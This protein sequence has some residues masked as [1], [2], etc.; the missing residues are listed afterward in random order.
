MNPSKSD[1][2]G[3]DYEDFTLHDYAPDSHIKAPV[4]V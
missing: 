4:A 1:L 2:F 3:W